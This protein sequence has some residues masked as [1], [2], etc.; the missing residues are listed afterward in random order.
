MTVKRDTALKENDRSFIAGLMLRSVTIESIREQLEKRNRDENTPYGDGSFSLSSVTIWK[1]CKI[2]LSE[3]KAE[4]EEYLDERIDLEL[5]K[6]DYIEEACWVAWDE[7]RDGK[8]RTKI[9][10]GTVLKDGTVL[11]GNVKERTLESG[12]GD[13]RY[14]EKIQ[15]CIDKRLEILGF[16]TKHIDLTSKGRRIKGAGSVKITYAG[17]NEE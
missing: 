4:R 13:T 11:A 2:I 9:E 8:H 5:K 1:E 17:V 3:W 7:S 14:I 10:G 6:I 15:W 12:S 16:K